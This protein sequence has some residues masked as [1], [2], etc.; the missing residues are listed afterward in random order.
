MNTK[1][2]VLITGAARN[3][4]FGMAQKFASEGYNVCITARKK[5]DAQ[6]A[7]NE[8]MEKYPDI[9]ARGY[10]MEAT[11]VDS[12]RRVFANV[13][14]EF[15]R[16]DALV[17]NAA[18]PGYNQSILTATPEQFDFVYKCNARGY[19]F[20]CQEAAKIMVKQKKGSIVLIG[21]VHSKSA[22]PNRITYAMSKGAIDT[23]NRNIAYELGKFNVRCNLV[24]V[25][26][27]YNDRW[28]GMTEEDYQ[29]KRNNWPIAMESYPKDIANAAYYLASDLSPTTTGS[30]ITVDSGVGVCML[31]YDKDWDSKLDERINKMK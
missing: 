6:R 22:I 16:L 9:I 5:D 11:D 7:A 27:T 17:N 2:V 13:Y 1:P 14:G 10:G 25:G 31:Q 15:E 12:I 20:C 18:D 19:F 24:V 8:V 21:S 4:G 3:I 26:A 28:E 23:M 30:E 29:N